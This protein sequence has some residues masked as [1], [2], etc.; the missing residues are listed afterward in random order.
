M[1]LERL[2]ERSDAFGERLAELLDRGGQFDEVHGGTLAAAALSMEHGHSLRLLFA[3]GAPQSACALLRLQYEALLRAAWLT[4]AAQPNTAARLSSPLTPEAQQA[5]KNVSGALDM[6]SDLQKALAANPA[7]L[8]LVQPLVQIR[9]FS[10]IAM[11]SYVHAG[12]HPLIRALDGFPAQL[13]GTVVRQSN[14]MQHMAVRLLSRLARSD[15]GLHPG[16]VDAAWK[17]F[18]DCLPT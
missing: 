13:A 9:E 7:L 17:Q 14:A 16:E 2:L 5:A 6:L 15:G 18:T 4:Y 3:T 1:D 11:N 12:L 10:W 8:G